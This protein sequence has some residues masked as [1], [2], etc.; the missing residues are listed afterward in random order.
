MLLTERA[1]INKSQFAFVASDPGNKKPTKPQQKVVSKKSA[2]GPKSSSGVP[3]QSATTASTS[4]Q[5]KPPFVM[6]GSRD[7]EIK[8]GHQKTH[9][10]KAPVDVSIEIHYEVLAIYGAFKNLIYC[11]YPLR[12]YSYYIFYY[13]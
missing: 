7:K 9:N 4:Q 3:K 12:N 2:V 11:Y 13:I 1:V 8:I 6:Y 5:H 10:I